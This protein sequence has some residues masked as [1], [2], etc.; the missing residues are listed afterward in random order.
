MYDSQEGGGNRDGL[1]SAIGNEVT[2]VVAK[3]KEIGIDVVS[4]G[5]VGK[6]GFSNYVQNRL[7]GLGGHCDG[8]LFHDLAE[9]PKLQDD[10]FGSEA[11][12]LR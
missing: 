2:Q 6:P 1:W 3:Q 11:A 8:W 5:E 12:A 9:V 10:Q 7:E 4:D